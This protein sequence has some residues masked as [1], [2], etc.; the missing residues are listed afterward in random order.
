MYFTSSLSIPVLARCK[1]VSELLTLIAFARFCALITL[2]PKEL[3][4]LLRFKE[5][6]ML[7]S[8]KASNLQFLFMPLSPTPSKQP[9]LCPAK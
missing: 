2:L 9:Y 4:V 8:A 6:I 7:F 5:R 3:S 1:D